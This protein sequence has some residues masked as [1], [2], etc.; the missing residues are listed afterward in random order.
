MVLFLLARIRH[1]HSPGRGCVFEQGPRTFQH[2]P[3]YS[4]LLRHIHW[5]DYRD[6]HRATQG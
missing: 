5:F 2:R 1:S 4:R 6:V 3:R